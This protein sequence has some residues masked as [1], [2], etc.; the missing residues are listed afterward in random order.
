[1]LDWEI[2]FCPL[3]LHSRWQLEQH[4]SKDA[5]HNHYRTFLVALDHMDLVQSIPKDVGKKPDDMAA[6]VCLV[7]T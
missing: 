7:S 2:G 5:M 1:M 3:Q 4:A 6:C